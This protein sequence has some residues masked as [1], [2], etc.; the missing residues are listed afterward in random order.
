M[1]RRGGWR[2]GTGYKCAMSLHA[3]HEL[4]LV[5][6]IVYSMFGV[7]RALEIILNSLESFREL[8]RIRE[9]V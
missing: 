5:A 6:C 1:E 9:H 7:D 4:S 2:V 8:Q 3:G